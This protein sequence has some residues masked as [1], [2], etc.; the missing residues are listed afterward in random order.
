LS[1][2]EKLYTPE[3]VA[4]LLGVTHVAVRVEW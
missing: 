3:E 1:G 4:E 2:E